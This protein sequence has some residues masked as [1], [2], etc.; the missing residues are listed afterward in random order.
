MKKLVKVLSA[1]AIIATLFGTA[2]AQFAKPKNAIEY[3]KAVMT[4][5]GHHFSAIAAVV[6]GQKPYDTRDVVQNASLVETF[7][8]LPWDAFLVP[9]SDKGA[10]HLKAA[11]FK[12]KSKFKEEGKKLEVE[13]AKLVTAANGGN[14]DTLKKQ[15]GQVAQSCGSCHKRFRD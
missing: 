6:K 3:R 12:Q 1:L 5:I 4:L 2:Y 14:L 9:G 11:A 8:K 10:T 13:A 15:F 7:S